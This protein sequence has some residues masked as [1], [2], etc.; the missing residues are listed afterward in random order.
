MAVLLPAL[1][2]ARTQAKRIVC[3]SGLKQLVL[4]WMSYAENND[5][6]LVNGG[7]AIT[8]TNPPVTET[9]WSTSFNTT[10]DPGWDWDWVTNAFDGYTGPPLTYEQRVAK[11]KK[12]ALFRY[13]SNIKSYRCPEADKVM[14][15]TYVMPTSMNASWQGGGADDYPVGKVAKRLGQIKQSKDRVVFFEEK[16]ISP[17]AFQ[18]PYRLNGTLCDAPNIMH[19]NGGNFGFADGHAEYHQYECA[20]TIQWC[21]IGSSYNST[22]AKDTCFNSTSPPKDRAWLRTAIWG[23]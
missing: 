9:Y 8:N 18:F 10:A 15:R 22:V 7:Q 5:G 1:A 16:Q 23:D 20:A 3:L 2:K 14:H 19:G 21:K 12:G 17:D 6:K 4:G 13:C 11:L